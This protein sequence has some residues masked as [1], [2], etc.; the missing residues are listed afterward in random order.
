MRDFVT[1]TTRQVCEQHGVRIAPEV[2][3]GFPGPKDT[4]LEAPVSIRNGVYDVDFIGAY[5]YL[6]GR[7]TF[8]RHVS[9]IGRFCSIASNVIAGQVEHPTDFI[10]ASPVLTGFD[11]FGDLSWF[12][13]RN[14]VFVS[15]GIS[16]LQASMSNRI[17]KIK[18]GND[19][20]IGE[21]AFIRRGVTLGD[22]AIVAARAVVTKDVPPYAIVGGTPA[23]VLRYRF[24]PDVIA[25]L[26]ALQWWNYGLTAL[27][28]VDF[29]DIGTALP[30]IEHNI[31]S[32]AASPYNG[33]L[34]NLGADGEV[35]IGRYDP[36]RNEIVRQ[37]RR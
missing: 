30:A 20:W 13:D 2:L 10:S 33:T 26:L 16:T 6:G 1:T 8:I 7:E 35:E 34:V 24:E 28:G 4:L 22:G 25:K 31:A 9:S 23:R 27:A 11:E 29:T 14:R 32:E 15:K 21:G 17:E 3:F 19:V 5:T 12:Y 37:D 18:I 36:D